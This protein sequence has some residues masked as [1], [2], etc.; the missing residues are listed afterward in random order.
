MQLNRRI[1]LAVTIAAVTTLSVWAAVAQADTT[2]VRVPFF[3]CA[4]GSPA[5]KAVPANT[6]LFFSSG[7]TEG[8]FGLVKAAVGKVVNT[9]TVTYPDGRSVSVNPDFQAIVQNA[10]GTWTAPFR[11][12]FG[13]LQA[14]QSVTIHWTGVYTGPI[15]DVIP[16]S[17]DWNPVA[18]GFPPWDGTGRKYQNHNDPGAFDKGTCTVTA[19]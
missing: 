12:D 6:T 16:P 5:A 13:S 18:N 3:A 9:F 4:A 17:D 7:W 8:T 1:S 14:G 2:P 10:D 11:V 19:T 15:E